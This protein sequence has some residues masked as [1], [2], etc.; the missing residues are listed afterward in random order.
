M[1][2]TDKD[3]GLGSPGKR[4]ADSVNPDGITAT[5]SWGNPNSTAQL[6]LPNPRNAMRRLKRS[7]ALI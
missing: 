4:P 7:P 1:A 5:E 3:I 6:C 2:I